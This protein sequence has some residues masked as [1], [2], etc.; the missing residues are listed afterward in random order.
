MRARLPAAGTNFPSN[1]RFQPTAAPPTA[2]E[3]FSSLLTFRRM[4]T[5]LSRGP[6]PHL[7]ELLARYLEEYLGKI[8]AA[9]APMSDDALWR[10]PEEPVN[11]VANLMIHLA[12]NLS[13]W[14]LHGLD[15]RTIERHRSAEFAARGGLDRTELRARLAGVVSECTAVLRGFDPTRAH[16][17]ADIQGYS[18]DRLGAAVH[19]V[20]H[21][22]YHTGQIV[23]LSKLLAPTSGIELYP[24]HQHE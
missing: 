6:V 12:G 24:Q 11:S 4:Q 21:M 2:G 9:I 5:A 18:I 17:V 10:R 16:E 8:D 23:Q 14:I 22:S 19:A 13:L 20:E 1:F 15:G 3:C 7:G